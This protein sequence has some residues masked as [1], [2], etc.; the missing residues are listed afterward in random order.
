MSTASVAR[1]SSLPTAS[2]VAVGA[3]VA[4]FPVPLFA[5]V[6]GA[7]VTASLV[8]GSRRRLVGLGAVVGLLG[9]LGYVAGWVA[10]AFV[11]DGVFPPVLPGGEAFTGFAVYIAGLDILGGMVGAVVGNALASRVR[12]RRDEG[13]ADGPDA[14]EVE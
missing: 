8:R 14:P 2:A 11:L 12:G 3:V 10:L 13:S 5:P 1:D 9:A 4:A 7:G 6:V